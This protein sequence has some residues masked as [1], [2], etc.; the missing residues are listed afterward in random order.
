MVVIGTIFFIEIKFLI[1]ALYEDTIEMLGGDIFK[2]ITQFSILGGFYE[3]I[4]KI[5]TNF[6]HVEGSNF[7]SHL[8]KQF[9]KY[10]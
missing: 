2:I 1:L 3:Q 4:I 8:V 5:T 9:Y 10:Y 7:L 6:Q